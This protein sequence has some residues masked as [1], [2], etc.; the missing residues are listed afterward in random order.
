MAPSIALIL[1]LI[2]VALTVIISEKLHM[3]IGLVGFAFAFILGIGFCGYSSGQMAGFFPSSIFVTQLSVTFFFGFISSTGFFKGVGDRVIYAFRNNTKAIPFVL[4]IAAYCVGALGAGNEATPLVISPLAF[5]FALEAGFDPVISAMAVYGGS[6]WGG[7]LPWTSGA[8]LFGFCQSAIGEEAGTKAMWAALIGL[9]IV[10]WVMMLAD[11]FIFGGTKMKKGAQLNI[12]EP[13]PFTELQKKGLWM[14][15]IFI[16]L[17][18]G[19]SML[20]TFTGLPIFATLARIL[21]IRLVSLVMALIGIVMKLG[22]Y[23]DVFKNR[24]P[25]GLLVMLGGMC[26]LM[27][28]AGSM[29]VVQMLGDWIGNKVP[30]ALVPAAFCLLGGLLS[31]ITNGLTLWPM[32]TAMVPTMAAASGLNP[33]YLCCMAMVGSMPSGVSPIST[34]GA[35]ATI[36][37]DDEA[38]TKVFWKQMLVAAVGV[39]F[40]VIFTLLGGYKLIC[41]FF[42]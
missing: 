40:N 11:F 5:A 38:R 12:K 23:K 36:G 7:S 22:D 1:F 41:S 32:F 2:A 28:V 4:A 29:G 33:I 6:C 25:W 39:V 30:V 20:K 8:M 9:F 15:V 19:P 3:N 26:T 18:I 27:N 16:I 24:I 10:F 13:E 21:D 31:F 14:T 37:F 17:V 35:M 42:I 34:G